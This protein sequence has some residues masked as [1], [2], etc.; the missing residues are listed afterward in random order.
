MSLNTMRESFKRSA[1]WVMG[2]VTVAM[3]ITTFSN[4]GSSLRGGAAVS[5]SAA[6]GDEVV[7]TVNGLDIK[8]SEYDKEIE[9]LRQMQQMSGQPSSIMQDGFLGVR[10][11]DQLMQTKLDM[12][13]AEKQGLTVSDAELAKARENIAT[14]YDIRTKLSL[15]KTA[16]IADIDAAYAKAGEPTFTERVDND[17]LRQSVL[18]QKLQDKVK[19]AVP[20]TEQDVRNSYRQYHTRHILIDNKKRSDEQ[21]LKQAQ[22]ILAKAKAPGADFAALAKQYS[23]DPGTKDKG[24]DDGWIDQN[25]TYVDEFK[26]AAFTLQPGQVTP[27]LVKSPQYGYF[28]IKLDE[29]RDNLPKDFDK[30][31]ASLTAQYTQA[32]QGKAWDTFEKGLKDDPGVKI[33]IN[34]PA[35]RGGHS[36]MQSLSAKDQPSRDALM[37]AALADYQTALAK[38]PKSSDAASINILMGQIAGQLHQDN[39][40]INYFKAALAHTDD[41]QLHMT[42]GQLYMKQKNDAQAI[43]QFQAASKQ[44]WD[45]QQLHQMLMMNYMQM[46]HP[47]LVKQEQQWMADYQKQHPQ[48][49]NNFGGPGMPGGPAGAPTVVTAPTGVPAGAIHITTPPASGVKATAG[50]AP[51]APAPKPAQ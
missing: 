4:L 15:P 50:T 37:K 16:T 32:Q 31:K 10:G 33:T 6:N 3:V 44:A 25:T 14:Q 5:N 11:F 7:A 34:D 38:N 29:V 40:A 18:L 42:L 46:K 51:S 24:G 26:K 35:I 39:D 27:D 30:N 48:P 12:Q 47:E 45:D 21:A 19:N 13:T 49:A 28:I 23:E 22:D 8:R 17:A 9:N 1:P 20:V 2:F 41:A 43:E 36:I